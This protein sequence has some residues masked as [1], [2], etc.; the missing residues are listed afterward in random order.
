MPEGEKDS[1]DVTLND[2]SPNTTGGTEPI[3]TFPNDS[4]SATKGNRKRY[5]DS[6]G[7]E[8]TLTIEDVSNERTA[9][10]DEMDIS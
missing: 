7:T 5:F 1:D 8:S 2:P 4:L 10:E 9:E 3:V 6:V